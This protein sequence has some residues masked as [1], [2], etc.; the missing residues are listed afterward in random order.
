MEVVTEYSL[1][2]F[3]VLKH[4]KKATAIYN[5]EARTYEELSLKMGDTIEVVSKDRTVTGAEGWWLGRVQGTKRYGLF[6]FNYVR[7]HKDE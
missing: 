3:N 6:P 4:R 5:Y 1:P 2:V 7:I